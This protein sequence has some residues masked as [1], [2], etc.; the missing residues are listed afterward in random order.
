[1]MV[2]GELSLPVFIS[3]RE[4]FIILSLPSPAE[5]GSDRVA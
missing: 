1:M 5:E 3:T 4:P 2:I